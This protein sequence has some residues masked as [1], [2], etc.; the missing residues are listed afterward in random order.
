MN[1]APACTASSAPAASLGSELD[2]WTLLPFL[3]L[4]ASIAVV[5]LFA[6]R[7]WARPLH[8]S[9]VA[10]LFGLPIAAYLALSFGAEG[11]RALLGQVHDYL[12][13]ITLLATLFVITSGILVRGSLSG[14]PLFNTALL[15]IGALL[16]NL[17]GTTGASVLLV[18]P[19]LRANRSRHRQAHVVVFFIFVVS[20]CGGLLT[21]L[22]DPP[23][24]L[25]F[26]RGV[27]FEW[28]FSL[29]PVWLL[30]VATLLVVFNLVDQAIL[31]REELE[32]P[33]SQLEELQV[34]EPLR[35]E[36]AHNFLFLLLV[37]L[38]V[39]ASGK[40]LF[41]GGTP[42]PI[43]VQ[44]S[45][46]LA[47]AAAAFA[48]TRA[49]IRVENHFEFAPF[50]EVAI[51]FAGIFL[52]MAPALEI[53]NAWGLGQR[54]VLGAEFG[55]SQPGQFFW[56]TGALSSFLDNAPTYATMAATA[57]GTAG[58]QAEGPFLA[59][60]LALGP[61]A[62]RLLAAIACGAVLMGANTY[63]G[64]GPNL[65]VRAIAESRGVRMPSFFGY[66]LWS[67]LILLPLWGLVTMVFLR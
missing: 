48:T 1:A 56:V 19:L 14:T 41:H 4:L 10:G 50:S 43:G 25:G 5:P 21:P 62:E 27:P 45:L 67:G 24:F 38:L 34:H 59:G 60:F 30:V 52:S 58:I 12:S 47:C 51:L 40:G 18:R 61:E 16:A 63:I 57:C 32:R 39:L 36:G 66:M 35:L 44:E 54:T 49:R 23:L 11:L 13:F 8:Q 64:N 46:M 31:S 26:L 55:L 28:T 42:W 2:L 9:L 17:I 6:R 33:G 3:G 22:G 37:I 7:W 65:M 29:W 15:G 20:N 53:L